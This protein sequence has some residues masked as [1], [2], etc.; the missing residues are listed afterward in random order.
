MMPFKHVLNKPN[1]N[2][3]EKKDKKMKQFLI[4]TLVALL[5][6]FNMTV[7]TGA[8][9]AY[10]Y[11]KDAPELNT[12]LLQEPKSSVIYDK[13]NKE[14]RYLVGK[15]YRKYTA[16]EDI[17]KNVQ[18]AFIAVEDIR[19]YDHAGIDIK[20]IA[21]AVLANI[22]NGFGSEGAS[23]ITQQVVK[24]SLLSSEKTLERK[25]NEAYLAVKLEENYSKNEI[26]EM[27]LN[28]IYFGEGAYGVAAAADTYFNKS[29]HQLTTAEIAL[30]AGLPQRPSGYNPYNYPKVAEERRNTV[31][32][33]MKKHEVI[34]EEEDK[35]AKRIPVEEML[36]I[37]KQN[38]SQYDAFIDKVVKEL[39]DKGISETVI[40]NGGLKIYT[41]L[42]QD[43][44]THVEKVLSTDEY[45]TYQD[46]QLRSGIVLMDTQTGEIR[47]IGSRRNGEE[48]V[49]KGWNY[50]LD[51]KRQPG[52]TV[53]PIL[54]YGPGI[55]HFKWSTYEQFLDEKVEIYGKEIQNWDEEYHGY[56]DMSESLRQS[57]NIPAVKAY[58][59]VGPE[60]AKAFAEKVGLK[61]DEIYPSYAIGGFKHGLSPLDLAGAY[62]AF[63]NR[64]MY[65]EPYAV[66]KV[67]FPDGK[68]EQYGSEPVQAMHDYTAYMM[69]DLLKTVVEKGTGRAAAV[70]GLPVAG[71]TGTTNLPEGISGKGTADVWFAGF[72]TRY[73]AAVWSGYDA[74]TQETYIKEQ[75][76]DVSK[77]IFKEVI[78]YVSKNIETPDFT[79]PSSVMA[80][81][82][83]K[84]TGLQANS[85]TPASQKV[86]ELYVKGTSPKRIPTLD[87]KKKNSKK[88]SKFVLSSSQ[89]Q[90]EV[91]TAEQQ[92][93]VREKQA[94]TV[95]EEP[96][97]PVKDEQQKQEEQVVKERQ[98]K[99]EVKEEELKKSE[100]PIEEAPAEQPQEQESQEQPETEEKPKE[101]PKQEEVKEEE[102]PQ[103]EE[104]PKQESKSKLEEKPKQE[105]KSEEEVKAQENQK[106]E[107]TKQPTEETAKDEKQTD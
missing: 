74:T 69:T 106:P 70:E 6:V 42:D 80:V 12:E 7:I 15:E 36:Y 93:E 23:T 5:I 65:Q 39:V 55:E 103:P 85:S 66:K 30:L 58:L 26:L 41:T 28:N 2:V 32:A 64:G 81:E 43:A 48:K 19:F 92:K 47:A 67:V 102:E 52:S 11:L 89:L 105:S 29:L 96:K 75:Y 98:T 99:P 68:E 72:T 25:I 56:I 71:K 16:I 22:K 54:A 51:N 88:E 17:P 33:L 35:E 101:Q 97:Q 27:Y 60:K 78:A 77:E 59:E 86:T 82:I 104:K 14:V 49:A 34:T 9:S 45:V 83:D 63:G 107:E 40:Y 38:E 1:R 95:Q 61:L 37:K 57:Y 46:E 50:A 91:Q 20:R 73:T 10:A 100:Q 94:E 4:M 44:Q 31:L 79:K 90:E 53:K 21:G 24:N 3:K 13:D 87:A 84:K 76:D 8:V 62:A 18:R